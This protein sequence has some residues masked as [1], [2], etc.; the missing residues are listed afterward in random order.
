VFRIAPSCAGNERADQ[1]HACSVFPQ[2]RRDRSV[3]PSWPP[4][5]FVYSRP[6]GRQPS[7]PH[8]TYTRHVSVA[9]PS[10]SAITPTSARRREGRERRRVAQSGGSAALTLSLEATLYA[11]VLTSD[12]QVA[13]RARN[14]PRRELHRP[15]PGDFRGRGPRE[16]RP[17]CPAWHL[18]PPSSI[19]FL[20]PPSPPP[21]ARVGRIL[22]DVLSA[23]FGGHGYELHVFLGWSSD[24]ATRHRPS[25]P[26]SAGRP[27]TGRL[28]DRL[29][30]RV[31]GRW[32]SEPPDI[33]HLV[34]RPPRHRRPS[35]RATRSPF[36]PTLRAL[37][38]F[39]SG[40]STVTTLGAFSRPHAGDRYLRRPR[41]PSA[42][43]VPLS[44]P[45]RHDAGTTSPASSSPF[46]VAH[47][48]GR[49]A[50]AGSHPS[51]GSLCRRS[52]RFAARGQPRARDLSRYSDY[53]SLA[54]R[55]RSAPPTDF[56]DYAAYAASI[57]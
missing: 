47:Q 57:V 19:Q 1:T 14:S 7:C 5:I 13:G 24:L 28:P 39:L 8:R 48:H 41:Q 27:A 3:Q 20:F 36:A 26:C 44:R 31:T 18:R 9:T 17:R 37:P 25:P 46:A 53:P 29:R 11:R 49:K 51:R 30:G 56:H 10:R 23:G 55:R 4:C 15:R 50:C 43:P 32:D 16:R 45:G 35:R 12:G 21:S 40:S 2:A 42:R 6:L 33:R 54:V 52:R 22:D 38:G 34:V